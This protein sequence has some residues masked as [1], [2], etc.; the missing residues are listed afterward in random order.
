MS[1]FDFGHRKDKFEAYL[2]DGKKTIDTGYLYQ[3]LLTIGGWYF[4]P[5]KGSGWRTFYNRWYINPSKDDVEF[6][7]LGEEVT[8]FINLSKTK[9]GK[10][11]IKVNGSDE[12]IDPAI[13]ER[14]QLYIDHITHKAKN[15]YIV[16]FP[17]DRNDD[18]RMFR[19]K[20]MA[21]VFIKTLSQTLTKHMK[22]NYGIQ[23]YAPGEIEPELDIRGVLE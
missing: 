6:F 20:A 9:F 13:I 3:E 1:W 10:L 14:W 2:P 17:N 15:S 4:A 23:L 12:D 11:T 19:T 21:M 7:G 8:A 5:V 18:A 22:E 16:V